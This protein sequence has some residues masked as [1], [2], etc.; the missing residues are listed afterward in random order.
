L[1]S[2]HHAVKVEGTPLPIVKVE[3]PPYPTGLGNHQ[4]AEQGSSC[5]QSA[6][7]FDETDSDVV[8]DM[9]DQYVHAKVCNWF[10]CHLGLY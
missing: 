7:G 3:V 6:T 4:R 5:G 10:Q 1:Y 9:D 2:P 8:S